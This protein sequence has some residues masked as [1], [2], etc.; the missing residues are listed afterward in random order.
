MTGRNE[1]V[2]GAPASLKSCVVILYTSEIIVETAAPKL[3]SLNTV[4][5]IGCQGGRDHM[6]TLNH[7]TQGGCG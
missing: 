6:A 7:Q 5:I 4:G 2:K 1:C 3:G